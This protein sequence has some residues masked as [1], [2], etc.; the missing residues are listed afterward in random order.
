VYIE[1][2]YEVWLAVRDPPVSFQF[3]GS[4]KVENAI[5]DLQQQ[6]FGVKD[7]LDPSSRTQK[8]G[9]DRLLRD[10]AG[11][12]LQINWKDCLIACDISGRT[13]DWNLNV[14][15][16][17]DIRRQKLNHEV[18]VFDDEKELDDNL[19]CDGLFG[20]IFL[21][22]RVD[23]VTV[24]VYVPEIGVFEQA[25]MAVST[26]KVVILQIVERWKQLKDRKWVIMAGET[27]MAK[28]ARLFSIF[29]LNK[30][31]P[32][33][34]L[35]PAIL[36]FAI[37]IG[38]RD[39][40]Y[41]L[42]RRLSIADLRHRLEKQFAFNRRT[43]GE[44]RITFGKAVPSQYA[45]ISSLLG[46]QKRKLTVVSTD[47][48]IML[49]FQ[50]NTESR[51]SGALY[52]DLNEKV[53]AVVAHFNTPDRTCRFQRGSK[54]IFQ[55]QSADLAD[56]ADVDGLIIVTPVLSP[57]HADRQVPAVGPNPPSPKAR[58]QAQVP[59]TRCP[60]PH[61][62]DASPNVVQRDQEPAP[63]I[64]VVPK[65]LA[66]GINVQK[67]V[68]ETRHPERFCRQCY[69]FHSYDYAKTLSALKAVK[70]KS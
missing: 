29:F 53:A 33:L 7:I 43:G 67:L 42:D 46:L 35:A 70:P 30:P 44:W 31:A 61:D 13:N 6:G 57:E 59:A 19:P 49:H 62:V 17:G 66:Y 10:F 65:P 54:E 32:P 11:S 63:P 50:D 36:R 38:G 51:N 27:P 12:L 39:F 68:A 24:R 20:R 40:S 22:N 58:P 34:R 4:Y 1:C 18:F 26:A 64:C 45:Q 47:V 8:L 52:F 5:L 41:E 48:Q 25:V 69:N 21:V 16:V 2:Y 56:I 60:P 3:S 55:D 15:T 9:P 28:K 23:K 37:T 14:A